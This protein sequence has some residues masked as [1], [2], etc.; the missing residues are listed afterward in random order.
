[1]ARIKRS[2]VAKWLV[3]VQSARRFF[4]D[5]LKAS[6]EIVRFYQRSNTY[7]E[8][9]SDFGGIRKHRRFVP[10][11]IWGNLQV[12]VPSI[13]AGV[14]RVLVNARSEYEITSARSQEKWFNWLLPQIDWR[15]RRRKSLKT[16]FLRGWSATKVIWNRVP[17]EQESE[18]RT[19]DASIPPDS[20]FLWPLSCHEFVC[21]PDAQMDLSKAKWVAHRFRRPVDEI[22]REKAYAEDARGRVTG[23]SLNSTFADFYRGKPTPTGYDDQTRAEGYEIWVRNVGEMERKLLVITPESE[24]ALKFGPWPY[25]EIET[26]PFGITMFHEPEDEEDME[27][28][29][30]I[31]EMRAW[32]PLQNALKILLSKAVVH[33]D[34]FDRKFAINPNNIDSKED[35]EKVVTGGDGTYFMVTPNTDD[36]RKA[37]MGIDYGALPAEYPV[38]L[39]MVKQMLDEVSG[40]GEIQ[41]GQA[42]TTV[43]ATTSTLQQQNASVRAQDRRVVMAEADVK[44]LRLMKQMAQ[45]FMSAET[46]I[47]V[48]GPEGTE[49][50]GISGDVLRAETDVRIDVD[51]LAP[52]SLDERKGRWLQILQM[53]GPILMGQ[54][55][56]PA[57]IRE[58][59]R[60]TLTDMRID[61]AGVF[62]PPMTAGIPEEEN[63]AWL[64]GEHPQALPTDDHA[65]HIASHTAFLGKPQM[66]SLPGLAEEIQAHIANHQDMMAKARASGGLSVRGRLRPMAPAPG[67]PGGMTG[68]PMGEESVT[69]APSMPA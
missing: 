58:L 68:A 31:P 22:K 59:I 30:P 24:D 27:P 48:S 47:P 49:W 67:T 66:A 42:P 20:P 57:A 7:L 21:D 1:V 40:I 4:E 33:V 43:A 55:G 65:A 52:E 32:V 56:V 5:Q 15:A 54:Q 28:A 35:L 45:E 25:A 19:L 3:R 17:G 26:F 2:E 46:L 38:L 61:D 34:R 23:T 10:N 11:Y 9:A 18:P 12:L 14:P 53:V 64:L 8:N 29:T 37:V 36:V 13:Y 44:L 41:R 51:S 69:A 50:L 60:R 16:A 63:S 6:E 62:L 39:T